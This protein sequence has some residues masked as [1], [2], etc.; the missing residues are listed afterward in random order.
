MAVFGPAPA[1]AKVPE[2]LGDAAFAAVAS[3][4]A[5]T[6]GL[7]FDESRRASL[8]HVVVERLEATGAADVGAYLARVASP[9][10]EAERQELLDAVV[11][12]ETHFLRN[13]PQMVALRRRILPELMRR[14]AARGRPVTVWS[15][16]CSTGEEPYSLAM[17]A[18]EVAAELAG[19]PPV[20]ITATDVSSRAVAATAAARYHGRSLALVPPEARER[21][22]EPVG[23]GW[24][25]VPAL[26]EMVEVSRHNLVTDAVPFAPGD[27]DLLVCR[28]VTI[29]FGRETTRTLVETFHDVL[30]PG[31]YLL[32][33]HAETLWQLN[34]DFAL[35]PMGDAFAYRRQGDAVPLPVA[36]QDEEGDDPAPAPARDDLG[37]RLERLRERPA[38]SATVA[39]P[40]VRRG[41]YLDR[42]GAMARPGAPSR[43]GPGV[44]APDPGA[45]HALLAGARAALAGARYAEAARLASRAGL[46]SPQEPEAAVVEGVARATVGDD[47]GAL[48]AL[49]RAVTLDP[50]AG[51]AHFLLA[52][53]LARTGRPAMA[54]REYREAAHTLPQTPVADL[55]DL[56]DGCDVAELVALC[57]QLADE[58]EGSAPA[59]PGTRS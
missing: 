32:V 18:A 49:R 58:A 23:P 29:Y 54:A 30:A 56:L 44:P 50:A 17:L 47:E 8:A 19:A 36:R 48:L 52:G 21:W 42:L 37:S 7:A 24:R 20:R 16:G 43:S 4:L 55:D 2:A 25:V 33:G 57:A 11:V 38:R 3:Y 31:G 27:V 51:H 14:A 34:E 9:D 59:A 35:V 6:A 53:A 10:G 40:R 45:A 5:R 26:R 46:A 15:A 13:P 22:F 1:P 12:P 39:P 41:G 28:N